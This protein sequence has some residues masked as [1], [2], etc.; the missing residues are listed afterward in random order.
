MN[1]FQVEIK[2]SKWKLL[3]NFMQQFFLLNL[4]ENIVFF[5]I[6]ESLALNCPT[7][8]AEVSGILTD[9]HP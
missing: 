8:Y 1:M 4:T 7:F 3:T 6:L 2:Y 5:I 9:F